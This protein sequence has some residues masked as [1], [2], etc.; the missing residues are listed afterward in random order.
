MCGGLRTNR[1]TKKRCGGLG[2]TALPE[3]GAAVSG[4]PPYQKTVGRDALIAP[5]G[6]ERGIAHAEN[7]VGAEEN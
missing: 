2:E 4:R 6:K 5:Q 1:P 7:A 3:N